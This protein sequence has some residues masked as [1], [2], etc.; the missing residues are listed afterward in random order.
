MDSKVNSDNR[1]IKM[2]SDFHTG[3]SP[4][5]FEVTIHL[6]ITVGQGRGLPLGVLTQT[7]GGGRQLVAFISKL[8]DS[9][10]RGWPECVQAVAA[11]AFLVQESRKLTFREAFIVN[12][13]YQVRSILSQKAGRWL[14]DS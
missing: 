6:F 7:W 14:T 10:F 4:T 9:V 13:P 8:L 2:G 5:V 12:S 3:P 11:T 1:G